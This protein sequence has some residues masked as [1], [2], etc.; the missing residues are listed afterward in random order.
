MKVTLDDLEAFLRQRP[1]RDVP[2]NIL[3]RRV[4]AGLGWFSLLFGGAF[5]GIGTVFVAIFFPW[6]WTAE[7]SLDRGNGETA[8]AVVTG[9]EPT[10]MTVND[11]RVHRISYRFAGPSGEVKG[12][13]Y[14]TGRAPD[15]DSVVEVNFLEHDPQTNRL[16]G[17]RIDPFGYF[18]GFVIIFP[19]VGLI[20]MLSA[21]WFRRHQMRLLKH[22]QFA[23][24]TV[25]EIRQTNV[26]VNDQRRYQIQ[27]AF[28][29]S[30]TDRIHNHN[31]YGEEVRLARSH[32]ES[33]EPIGVLYDPAKPSRLLFAEAL[34]SD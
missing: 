9:N 26:T 8:E 2:R 25:Q 6:N 16:V 21:H 1:P 10:N 29:D 31:A 17:G 11:R 28:D 23:M 30:T 34:L 18:G 22:S 19:F 14:F 12:E 33:G 15:V 3:R 24:A 4:P 13:C 32:L 5:L 20:V 7:L 27:L